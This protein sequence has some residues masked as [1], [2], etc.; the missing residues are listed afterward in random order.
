[1]AETIIG[2]V[3]MIYVSII[4]IGIGIA[5]IRSKDPVGFYTGEKPPRKEQLSD[6]KMWNK[7]HGMLWI[8]YGVAII[9]AFVLSML[10]NEEVFSAVILIGVIVGALPVMIWYHNWLKK[11]YYKE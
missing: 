10:V 6:V 7:K 5:Q 3:I 11:K 8:S 4:M 9:V 1:M 2:F